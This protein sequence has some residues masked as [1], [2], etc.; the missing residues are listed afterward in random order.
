MPADK[1]KPAKKAASRSGSTARKTTAR[2]T[3]AGKTTAKPAARKTSTRKAPAKPR[4]P[5]REAE[6]QQAEVPAAETDELDETATMPAAGGP[7]VV[8]LPAGADAAETAA[9]VTGDAMSAEPGAAPVPGQE[10]PPLPER[11]PEDIPIMVVSAILA[12]STFLPWYRLKTLVPSPPTAT[13]FETGTWGPMIFFLGLASLL[14]GVLR[15]AKVRVG[16]PIADSHFHEFV[17]WIAIVGAV[18]KLRAL[19]VD[20]S[21]AMERSWGVFVA[22]GAAFV[23][24]FLA[25]RMSGS[26]PFTTIP[27][28][29]RGR[30][31]TLGLAMLAIVVAASAALGV[32][33]NQG[34][35]DLN[36]VAQ[37]GSTN[38]LEGK[39]PACS[40]GFPRVDDAKPLQGFE[41]QGQGCVFTYT[42]A[43]TTDDILTFYK[44]ELTKAGYRYEELA[45]RGDAAG[46]ALRLTA[47]SCGSMAIQP[48]QDGK[49]VTVIVAFGGPCPSA[50]ASPAATPSS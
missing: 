21:G 27:G 9:I 41:G 24:A 8:G 16:L 32:T 14:V 19:P 30:A 1:K 40:K 49:G 15:R 10:E 6:P 38:V 34:P 23:L 2:K 37:G 46:I 31:G 13:G 4:A 36:P 11:Y 17:G 18:I 22:I 26:A 44:S 50:Q 25:G 42:S 7:F 20:A 28:W 12:A 45:S 29:F 47:P 43:K 33:L 5:R 48:A 35:K 3:T 39:F